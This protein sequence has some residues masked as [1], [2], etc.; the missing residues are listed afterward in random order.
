[1]TTT[2]TANGLDC[3]TGQI[4][5]TESGPWTGR[6]EVDDELGVAI[7][8]A[9][10]I[11]AGTTVWNGT[12]TF[13]SVESGRYVAEVVGGA[14]GLN[15][16]LESKGYYQTTLGVILAD[17]MAETGEVLDPT[18][19]P[20]ILN[21]TVAAWVRARGEAR[22]AL[23]AVANEV[24][25]YWRVSRLGLVTIVTD[26][27]WLPLAGAYVE[28]DRDPGR[29]TVLIAPDEA[30]EAAPGRALGTERIVTTLTTWDGG[31]LRQLLHLHDGTDKAQDA[32]TV[33]ADLARRAN[34]NAITY[35][36]W[37]P[38]TVVAQDADGSLQL[39]PDD[40]KMRGNGLVKVPLRI[41]MPGVKVL[42][43]PGA[44]VRL[45]FEDADP[46]KP[47]AALWDQSSTAAQPL[48][49]GN[50][51]LSLL[52][53]LTVPT[54]MGPSGTPINAASFAT[55]LSATHKLES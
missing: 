33:A 42:V 14:N 51:L 24:G 1:M 53:A 49:L 54:A 31:S 47:A 32:A 41:G 11:T 52:S 50:T 38:C 15:T 6:I 23:Q 25:G 44:R 4:L 39:Y 22:L 17:I 34:E 21:H 16:V 35:S 12:V 10:V 27:A 8:G 37:Y 3:L 18:S 46:K 5:E 26:E 9:V 36:R 40:A 7:T 48:V 30:P 13:G 55:F 29:S 45:Y 19:S 43:S 2:I 20:T 28:E